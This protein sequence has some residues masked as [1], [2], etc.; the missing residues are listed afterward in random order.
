MGGRSSVLPFEPRLAL[1][2]LSSPAFGQGCAS[3]LIAERDRLTVSDL[4]IAGLGPL[5]GSPLSWAGMPD[6]DPGVRQ[7]I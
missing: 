7:E 4:D 5:S 3:L 2:L 6:R 1:V